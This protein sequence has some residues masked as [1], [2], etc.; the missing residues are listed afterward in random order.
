LKKNNPTLGLRTATSF[1][2]LHQVPI[3]TEA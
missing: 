1:C 3:S 2:I